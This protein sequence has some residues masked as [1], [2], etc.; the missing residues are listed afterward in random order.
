MALPQDPQ[1]A[2]SMID[3]MA[4]SK[5]GVSPQMAQPAPAAPKDKDSAEDKASAKGSPQTEGDKM[6]AEAI[7]YEID[8]GDGNKR[9]LTE[10]QIKSTFQRYAS[11]NHQNAQNGPIN[12]L[13]AKIQKANPNATSKQ[14]ADKIDNMLK[15]GK[16]N[17][18][19]GNTK[20]ERSGDA[21]KNEDADAM[22]TKWELDNAAT[23]PP[24]YREMMQGNGQQGQSMAAVRQEL[25][26]TQQMLQQVMAQTTGVADAAKSGLQQAE[27]TQIAAMQKQI[28]N[29]VDRVQAHLQLED[30]QAEP[31]MAFAA[32]R[33][34][35]MEDFINPQLTLK[36]MTDFK[37]NMNS[38]EMERIKAI[39]EKRQ[40]MTGSF[41]ST[42]TVGPAGEAPSASR[43]DDFAS[44]AMAGKGMT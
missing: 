18:T 43:F 23:L 15:A 11:L 3:Q 7:V 39:A 33:G 35:T 21:P 25:A 6:S 34:F 12:S 1:A 14:I 42:P 8:M 9:P 26:K 27:G 2:A 19:L 30:G 32:E 24:M 38:P 40:A 20:G 4:S 17:P 31:F 28:A 13:V 37:N 36:V 10:N 44:K 41:G 5:M 22:M 16:S 29:N